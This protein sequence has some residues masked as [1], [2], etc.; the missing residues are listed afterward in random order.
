MWMKRLCLAAMTAMATMT[1]LRSEAHTIAS[2]VKT[3][4]AKTPEVKTS[5][6]KEPK[7][8]AKTGK[9]SRS[10]SAFGNFGTSKEP[11]KID[12]ASLQVVDK[13]QKAIYSGDV[14]AIQGATTLRCSRLTVFYTQGKDKKDDKAKD[15]KIKDD[16]VA[17]ATTPPATGSSIKRLECD[18]PV[19][20]V[21]SSQTAT[22]DHGT[23]EADRELVTLTGNVVL[24]D[25]EN[26]QRG[27]KLVYNTKTGI[28]NVTNNGNRR[29][30]GVFTPG[31]DEKS[32]TPSKQTGCKDKK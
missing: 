1:T 16:K 19:S 7:G 11:V 21:S 5:G 28:A 10:G 12:A 22:G 24:A 2:P 8:D 4:D 23:F 29:V 6:A 20:V 32:P 3:Q 17:E 26:V 27:D 9:A 15:D 31:S 18:G 25:C 13:E 30:Q 14:V